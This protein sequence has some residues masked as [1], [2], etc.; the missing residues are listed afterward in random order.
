MGVIEISSG[1]AALIAA[2]F[3]A[4]M[5]VAFGY[6]ILTNKVRNNREDLERSDKV[7]KEEIRSMNDRFIRYETENK[8]EHREINTKL[9]KI[10]LNGRGSS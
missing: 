4:L 2:V 1:A 3:L 10:L 7:H 6:G 8:S 5:S 9:D